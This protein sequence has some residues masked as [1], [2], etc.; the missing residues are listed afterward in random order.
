MEIM[1]CSLILKPM[2]QILIMHCSLNDVKFPAVR[3]APLQGLHTKS[4][5]FGMI[6]VFQIAVIEIGR[7]TVYT[8]S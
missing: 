2:N 7:I 1:H 8:H 5:T 3:I 6:L 4:F